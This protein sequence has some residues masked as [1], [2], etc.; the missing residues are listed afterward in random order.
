[1]YDMNIKTIKI[2]ATDLLPKRESKSKERDG[3]FKKS[4][5]KDTHII[6]HLI[7][8]TIMTSFTF[9]FYLFFVSKKFKKNREKIYI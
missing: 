8:Q 9:Y 5:T 1:M 4:E 6:I 7:I 3:F 2:S